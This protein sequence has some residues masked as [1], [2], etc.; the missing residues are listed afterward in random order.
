[1]APEPSDYHSLM[2][3]D[4]TVI[5]PSREK[6]L[7]LAC[8]GAGFVALGFFLLRSTSTREHW[9]GLASILFFW[10]WLALRCCPDCA[11]NPDPHPSSLR[12]FYSWDRIF[13][14]G[15]NLGCIRDTDSKTV[16]SSSR[17]QRCRCFIEPPIMAESRTDENKS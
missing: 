10:S 15:R 2:T 13:A 5:Y 8:L 7:R 1:M 12:N 14:L 3:P 11:T 6:L 16:V 17:R 4:A 9:S